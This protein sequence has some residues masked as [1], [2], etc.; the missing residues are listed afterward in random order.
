MR[1]LT[2][3]FHPDAFGATVA[4]QGLSELGAAA[5][6]GAKDLGAVASEYQ[7][8]NN[9]N[10]ADSASLKNSID[11]SA[12]AE[13]YKTG[14]RSTLSANPGMDTA[15][16]LR[17]F[18]GKQEEAR[19]AIGA[20]MTNPMAK[21]LY[22]ND[23]RRSAQVLASNLASYT[24]QTWTAAGIKTADDKITVAQQQMGAN[25][26]DPVA[27]ANGLRQ[28]G[29][30][31]AAKHRLTGDASDPSADI[32]RAISPV[33][34]NAIAAKIDGHDIDGAKALYSAHAAE[35]TDD[36][37][38]KVEGALKAGVTANMIQDPVHQIYDL[39]QAPSIP[40]SG[41]A[42]VGTALSAVGAAA[43]YRSKGLP[44]NEAAA[45]A[46]QEHAESGNNPNPAGT[47]DGG[48]AYGAMQWHGDRQADFQAWAGKP[49]QQSTLQEQRDFAVYELTQGKRAA[50]GRQAATAETPEEAS[51]ILTRG[52]T[53][54]ADQSPAS[55]AA[56]SSVA[57][58]ISSGAAPP[59]VSFSEP[60]PRYTPQTDPAI[61]RDGFLSYNQRVAAAIPDAEIRARFLAVADSRANLTASIANDRQKGVF[62]AL[63]GYVSGGLPD[64]RAVSSFEDLPPSMTSQLS[65]G[66]TTALRENINRAV[67][68]YG[69]YH[70]PAMDTEAARQQGLANTN[71][72]LF[73]DPVRNNLITNPNL[74]AP[75]RDSLLRE[76]GRL[77]TSQA[78]QAANS[79]KLQTL[80]S[81]PIVRNT[82]NTIGLDIT[83]TDAAS[84]QRLSDR[85][86]E[87]LG[88]LEG[89]REA[90]HP[91]GK[92]F[93]PAEARQATAA[94]VLKH[95][96][97]LGNM[98]AFRDI[99]PAR[100]SQVVQALRAEGVANPQPWQILE[101]YRRVFPRGE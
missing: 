58:H 101:R 8:I 27:Q 7:A 13:T 51:D 45:L 20:G 6:Q 37:R 66:Y 31:I 41:E 34:R 95:S 46:A 65:P 87:F 56:R 42:G 98:E 50:V 9:Q 74:S 5:G 47:N 99:S 96:T 15:A 32:L 43:Y 14:L 21:S 24:A 48:A 25:Y 28:I 94:L 71:P 80:L 30:A 92:P 16:Y 59:A 10:S 39:G 57:A 40:T 72:A 84:A 90:M 85:R 91:D 78:A 89:V 49:I 61:I 26:D 12:D 67:A 36:D 52:Y 3:P 97:P 62:D 4:G 53:A 100:N 86:N 69:A 33:N 44:A 77:A 76:Q 55:L 1:A 38:A 79:Q 22:N 11:R 81:D 63:N 70:T 18:L 2:F 73:A 93:T 68:G 35:M 83:G 75:D 29:E 88:A 82:Y 60:P 17:D 54:P 23:T 19:Q 64:G